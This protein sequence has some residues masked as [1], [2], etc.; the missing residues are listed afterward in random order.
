MY[1]TTF[2]SRSY[3]LAQTVDQSIAG[4]FLPLSGRYAYKAGCCAS[5]PPCGFNFPTHSAHISSHELPPLQRI[6]ICPEMRHRSAHSS[7]LTPAEGVVRQSPVLRVPHQ[8]L[9]HHE[10]LE[11]VERRRQHARC[12][13]DAIGVGVT[14][15]CDAELALG[16]DEVVVCVAAVVLEIRQQR[17][18]A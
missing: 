17:L 18:A 1:I 16:E 15:G 10:T 3:T 12:P 5:L 11:E 7:V 13:C 14:Q 2:D 6:H 4:I 9:F 8:V